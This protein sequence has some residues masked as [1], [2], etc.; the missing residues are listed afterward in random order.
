MSCFLV[1]TPV[2]GDVRG[3]GLEW[4]GGEWLAHP[5]SDFG[6]V[7][8]IVVAAM[9]VG[10]RGGEN[11]YTVGFWVCSVGN[12]FSFLVVTPVEDDVG[13]CG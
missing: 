1:V 5:P 2:E 8:L 3:W 12:G 6:G 10:I 4:W 11:L 7:R 9:L 13:S